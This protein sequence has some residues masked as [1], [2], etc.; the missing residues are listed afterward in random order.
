M[1]SNSKLAKY[2]ILELMY[3]NRN[4]NLCWLWSNVSPFGIVLGLG[5]FGD[6]AADIT[7]T[8]KNGEIVEQ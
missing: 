3:Q 4:I 7:S 5:G 1:T 2:M 6:L 8:T